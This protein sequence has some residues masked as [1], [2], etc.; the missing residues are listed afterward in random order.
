M[1]TRSRGEECGVVAVL[2]RGR[3]AA[4]I[5]HRALLALQHRGQEAAGIVTS[6]EAGLHHTLKGR[7]LVANCL[8]AEKVGLLPGAL[9]VGHVRYSTVPEDRAENIQPVV[10]ESTFGALAIAHNGNLP[11]AEA[12]R[13][14]LRQEGAVFST[15]LDTEVLFHLLARS[16]CNDLKSA[17]ARV[18]AKLGGAYSLTLLN[19]GKVFGFR[20]ARGIRPLC[21]GQRD[22]A[23][24]LAS[25]TCALDAVGAKLVRE[26]E[27][28]EWVE[29]SKEGP[30]FAQL[31]PAP[32]PAPCAFEL[33]Y[34]SRPDSQVFGKGVY[35]A[36]VRMGE[37]LAR[38]DEGR[39]TG[40]VIIPIPD[41]G[42]PA[43][44]G[45][46]RTMNLPLEMGILRAH[47]MGRT[48]ILPAQDARTHGIRLKFSVVREVVQGR[49]VVLVDDSLV[50]GNT[51]RSI[52]QMVR[53]A[54][55][56]KVSMRIAS[57]PIAWP[58]NLGIDTP[59]REE[60]IVNRLHSPDAIA[61]HLGA[62]DLRY[63][64]LEGLQRAMGGT[65]YCFG[66]MTGA[67]PT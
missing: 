20:D 18:A 41:S 28:G 67:Y 22:D 50:R 12:L 27:P 39:A 37:A 63:L 65:G 3:P 16:G 53:D 46:A 4:E 35:S 29:L 17:V 2:S 5:A 45:Y 30:E 19:G 60:L 62:T 51:A 38:A 55:A 52:V 32:K 36:R 9:A 14:S 7:G 44:V 42:T 33:V 24:I 48:F 58:C 31:V 43:A 49:H 10:G 59:T 34:F 54:G 66:C 15:S 23:W 13:H 21:V 56:L 61:A 8:P 26:V 40:D 11:E 1:P 47:H 64:S 25:E 57:P 6:D